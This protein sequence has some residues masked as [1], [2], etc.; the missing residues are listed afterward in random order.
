MILAVNH[1]CLQSCD[2]VYDKKI[3]DRS[4]IGRFYFQFG[5]KIAGAVAA[6][7]F[8]KRKKVNYY[9]LVIIVYPI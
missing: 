7:D 1:I 4:W 8:I 2:F 5:V 9:S 3:L 6:R